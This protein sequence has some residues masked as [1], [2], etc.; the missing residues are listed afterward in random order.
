[1]FKLESG[2]LDKTRLIA[3]ILM[4]V[5][6]IGNIFFSV[7]YIQEIK[8]QNAPKVDNTSQ[9][10]QIARF[11]KEYI[12]IVLNNKNAVSTEDR[13]KLEN[14]EMQLHDADISNQWQ[15]FVNS[16]DAS[17]AQQNAVKLMSVL[18]DKMLP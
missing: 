7:Q 2:V 17:A 11:L 14:D 15:A 16:S 3:N 6:L 13:V 9:R 18:A 5:L 10:I 1:M 4:L 12:A 8:N